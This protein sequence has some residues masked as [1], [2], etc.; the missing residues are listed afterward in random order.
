MSHELIALI[1]F[2]VVYASIIFNLVPRSIIGLTGALLLILT[3]VLSLQDIGSYINWDALGL[4]FGMFV[5]VKILNES[6]FFDYLS[7]IVLKKTKGIPILILFYFAILAGLL[8]TVMDSITVLLFMS[9]LSIEIAKKLKVNPIP[10]IFSQ[11]TAANIGG[12]ATLIG[13]PPNII[14]GTGLNIIFVQ[15]LK[16]LA[17]ISIFILFLNTGYFVLY[18]R[19][20]FLSIK[21]MDQEYLGGLNAM[22]KVKDF[23]LMNSTLISFLITIILIFFRLRLE[24]SVGIVGLIGA[25]LALIL[26][27]KKMEHIWEGIEWE[28]LIFFITLFIIIGGL[29][30][31]NIINSLSQAV[32]NMTS[33]NASLSKNIL[34]WMSGILSGFVDNVPFAASMVPLLKGFTLLSKT[35]SLVSLGLIVTFGTD[36]GGNLTPIGASPNVVGLTVLSRA[37]VDVTWKN[38][39]KVI[40]P[41]TILDIF[42]AGFVFLIFFK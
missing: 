39:L 2:V 35:V 1:V 10:F 36:V 34:L 7:V 9:A 11:I 37:G 27:G 18:Y 40:V 28:V 3:G 26:S 41:I 17:P 21:P 15:F 23:T 12:S 31:T 33:N 8:S 32:V 24:L 4:I 38:Y 19:R 14:I 20:T 6:G 29:E 22:E 16:Y 30:K 42:V 13:N 25:S 5:L